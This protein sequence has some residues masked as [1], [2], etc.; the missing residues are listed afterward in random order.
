MTNI[1]FFEKQDKKSEKR[2]R[3]KIKRVNRER[4]AR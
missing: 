4:E 3:S 2:K 1:I